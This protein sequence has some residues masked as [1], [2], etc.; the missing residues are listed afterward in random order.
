M[1]R[2]YEMNWKISKIEEDT[3]P[4]ADL[5]KQH[6]ACVK[7]KNKQNLLTRDCR[8]HKGRNH[9]KFDS[10]LNLFLEIWISQQEDLQAQ[11]T[12]KRGYNPRN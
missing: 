7:Q 8:R 10:S 6:E 11:K 9:S 12:R 4:S 1:G 5:E 3:F 2:N